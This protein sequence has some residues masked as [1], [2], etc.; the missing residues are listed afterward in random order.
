[1][2]VIETTGTDATVFDLRI[3]VE[4]SETDG[5]TRNA[6]TASVKVRRPTGSP[7]EVKLD[8]VDICTYLS[9]LFMRLCNDDRENLPIFFYLFCHGPLTSACSDIHR[10]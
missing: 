3:A 8:N 9:I 4:L 5:A 7:Y 10:R 2:N 1:M 6:T